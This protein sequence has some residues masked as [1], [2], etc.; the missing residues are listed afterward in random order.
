MYCGCQK[1]LQMTPSQSSKGPDPK[2]VYLNKRKTDKCTY[3][4]KVIMIENIG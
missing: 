3:N 2:E 1:T 4:K